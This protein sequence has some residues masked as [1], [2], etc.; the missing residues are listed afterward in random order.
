MIRKRAFDIICSLVAILML[1]PFLVI[2][3]ALIYAKLGSPIL[4]KQSR[5][6]KD[7]KV[8]KIIKFRSM[9]N[10]TDKRGRLLSDEE[11][12]TP[13][14]RVIRKTSVDELPE[15]IN[16]LKGDMSLVGPRPLLVEYLP[17]YTESQRSRHEV[18]PG[19]TGW[20]QINGRNSISWAEKFEL[21]LWY[22][23]NWSFFLDIKI[24]LKTVVKVFKREGIS[25]KGKATMEKFNGYN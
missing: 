1:L 19:I 16:V 22:I 3:G 6:G 7:G 13:F 17:L 23:E 25:Q 2:T 14:G 12:L 4:F 11:R 9:L 8:F 18:L 24:L 15:L 20:A 10:S 21:D 5:V